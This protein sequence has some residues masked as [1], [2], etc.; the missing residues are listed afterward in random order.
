MGEYM[1][2]V[3]LILLTLLAVGCGHHGNAVTRGG[4]EPLAVVVDPGLATDMDNAELFQRQQ[5][6]DFMRKDLVLRL[7]RLGYEAESLRQRSDFVLG[8]GQSLLAVKIEHYRP[9]SK[10]ARI[11]VGMGAGAT[12]LNISYDITDET[13]QILT[14]ATD[15]VG[16]SRDWSFCCRA[17]N[18]RLIKV[19]GSELVAPN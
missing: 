2:R 12:S 11:I 7:K 3:I 15:G 14:S 9:G 16:S 17:L 5:V 4:G 19:V 1:S 6:A 13:G 18:D 10:A 8:R